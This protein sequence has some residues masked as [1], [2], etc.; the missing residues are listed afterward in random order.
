MF[1]EF[2]FIDLRL[3]Y[4]PFFSSLVLTFNIILVNVHN[5]YRKIVK[6]IFLATT[7]YFLIFAINYI[8]KFMSQL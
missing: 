6:L 4:V 8:S 5:Y 2:G 7:C 3:E 1:I